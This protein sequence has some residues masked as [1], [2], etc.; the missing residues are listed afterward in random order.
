MGKENVYTRRQVIRKTIISFAEFTALMGGGVATW[1]Y[2][3]KLP[4]DN[5]LLGGLQPPIRKVLTTNESIFNKS[6]SNDHLAK[7][8]PK[9]AALKKPRVN[10]NIGINKNFDASTWQLDVTT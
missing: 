9:S 5:G 6:L 7:S 1:L 2:I 3:K 8:Y 10:G 4:P